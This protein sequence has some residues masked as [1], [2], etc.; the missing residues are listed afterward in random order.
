VANARIDLHLS[1]KIV[2]A[3]VEN[4]NVTT[5]ARVTYQYGTLIIAIGTIVSFAFL[6]P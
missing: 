5:T 3:D 6:L 1:I 2:K 4:K